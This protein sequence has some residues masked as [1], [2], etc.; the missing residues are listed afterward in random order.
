MFTV[1][2][3][4]DANYV[5]PVVN[6]GPGLTKQEF[7]DESDVNNIMRKYQKQGIITWQSRVTPEFMQTDPIDFQDAMNIVNDSNRQFSELPSDIRKE[8]SND[9]KKFFEFV[10][11]PKNADKM[12]DLG[13]AK[14]PPDHQVPTQQV[15]KAP[16][17]VETNTPA[18]QA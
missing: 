3:S 10:S 11:D 4:Q 8:F 18:E 1:D 7:K 5:K 15:A 12:Y 6:T 9:P 14:R 13:I 16:D 17:T 2:R